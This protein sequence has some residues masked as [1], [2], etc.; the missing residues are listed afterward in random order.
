M[1]VTFGDFYIFEAWKLTKEPAILIGMD[2]IGVFD[3][4]V[5]DYKLK[6]LH[7][8]ARRG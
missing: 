7:L 4:V 2:V 8:K 1:Q 5:I 6:E 3:A